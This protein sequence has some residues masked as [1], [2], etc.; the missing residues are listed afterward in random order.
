MSPVLGVVVLS[1]VA[2][3]GGCASRWSRPNTSES[4][5]YQDRYQCEQDAA[6]SYPPAMVQRTTSPG[7]QAAPRASQTNCTT[8]GNNIS[9][10]T[11]PTGLDASIFN[12]PPTQVTEDVN[13][14]SR[15]SAVQSCLYARGYSRQ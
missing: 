9:C 15:N 2:L 13:I 1:S 7:F 6:R 3:L 10:N 8:I 5:F 14:G 4:Q 12:R 11:A